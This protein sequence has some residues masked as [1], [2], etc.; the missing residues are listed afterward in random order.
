MI[1][2]PL[3]A[4]ALA[5]TRFA[6][7]P[8]MQVG[9]VLHPHR[10]RTLGG[11]SLSYGEVSRVL[12]E[13]RLHLLA[14]IRELVHAFEPVFY[15]PVF[16][17]PPAAAGRTPEP[18]E[19]LHRIASAPSRVVAWQL[20]CLLGVQPKNGRAALAALRTLREAADRGEGDFA[21]RLACE[22]DTFWLRG[23]SRTWQTVAAQATDDIALRTR[24]LADH[25]MGYALGS[26]HEALCYGNGALRL[27]DRHSVEVSAGGH[28]VLFPSPWAH[29][30]VLTV[31]P[32]GRRPAFLVYPTSPSTASATTGRA[33]RPLEGKLGPTRYALL[34][35]LD[36]PRTT[37]Q[38]AALHHLSPST[39]SYHLA[40]LHRAG[41]VTRARTR[42][43]VYYQRTE[44][45]VGP[46]PTAATQ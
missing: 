10:P 24:L 28:L 3:S 18:S 32:Q 15:S 23:F 45:P 36:V 42:N 34:A 31:D 38:L 33:D 9:T 1:T 8:L 4:D 26:L 41:L 35:D 7:S 44:P 11:N 12:R 27:L 20:S 29:S 40:L 46:A 16:L 19:D 17:T 2:I 25:G 30:L 37:T 14:A 43:F 13:H 22:L 6:V 39:V 21:E 5:A